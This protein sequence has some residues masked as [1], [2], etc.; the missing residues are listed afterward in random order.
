MRL[1]RRVLV[2]AL[3]VA[4][5]AGLVAAVVPGFGRQATAA[6]TTA[7]WVPPTVSHTAFAGYGSVGQ[8]YVLN[9]P[10][11]ASLAL[12]RGGHHVGGGKADRF[13]SLIVRGLPAGPGY[14]IRV[15]STG[16]ST[17]PFRVLGAH[18]VPTQSFYADQHLHVGLNYLT[19]RDG[20]T[21][22]AT[23]RLPPGKTL[24][25]GPF[26]TVIE[27]S[28]Y[29]IAAPHSLI[30]ALLHPTPA[31]A[32]DPLLPDTATFVGS[33]LT[34]LLGFATVSL[35]MRGTG[36]SGGALGLFDLPTTYDGYD[37]V[38]IVAAQP[39]ALGHRVGL[40]GISF[41]GIS[42]LFVAGTR[43]PHLAAIAPLSVTDDLYS[44]GFPGGIFNAGFAGTWVAQREADAEPAPAGGQA[45]ARA[46]VA[47]GDQECAFNQRLRLETQDAFGLVSST[48][49]HR[50]PALFDPRSPSLWAKRIDVPVYLSGALE[51]EQ[52]GPQ[53]PALLPD[54]ANDRDVFVTMVN[55]THIDSLGPDS[56]TRW[57][58]FLDLYV[59]H[60]LPTI[61]SFV[62]ALS[63]ALYRQLAGAASMPLP[64][65]R[66]TNEPS[67]AAAQAAYERETP[68]VRVLFDNG[69]GDLGPGAFQPVW[70]ADYSAWPPPPGRATAY[71]LG[72]GGSLTTTVPPTGQASFRPDP[73]ARPKTDLASSA[74]PGVA[75]PPYDW[76]PV[77][78]T[79]GL[80][81]VTAPF[82]EDVV[83]V[84][85]AALDVWLRSTAPDTDLQATV[86]E[87]LPDGAERYLQSGFL[88]ASDRAL[89]PSSTPLHPVPTNLRATAR[90]L[91]AGRYTLVRIPLDPVVAAFRA[92]T[93]LRV[94]LSAPGGD[95]PVWS[96]LTPATGGAV[97]DT[98]D[99]GGSR[100]SV[101]LLD[102]IP[103]L[104]PP[105]PEPACPSTRGQPC[106]TYVPAGNGG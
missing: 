29:A 63:G 90:P 75:L 54:L 39:F 65:L 10:A 61:P 98:L 30:D 42:Q 69:G 95:R 53:W 105:D 28:G 72:G 68:R 18:D 13:G 12:L 47:D 81:F 25:D 16:R 21:L 52:T 89:A 11:G 94:T 4:V 66:F 8:A 106:R 37:A 64:A 46:L 102:V 67:V 17:A 38:E 31:S 45:Y 41:S 60:H 56:I 96:F 48:D 83:V 99:L 92:G 9:A 85:P 82:Q 20:V 78:G 32:H 1:A 34:P 19:M 36:C 86:S 71:Y 87:V 84:G 27:D 70:E 74:N 40:V 91:P 49:P 44:T 97:T 7:G 51:D 103:G 33:V 24:A 57:V 43:P 59:A 73:S 15:M 26:P 76:A 101:L 5:V 2:A 62:R 3:G 23:L 80:G 77:T 88:R 93:R 22:A 14:S 100:P 58:E 35:Q 104:R 79:D 50:D 6:A 55:G